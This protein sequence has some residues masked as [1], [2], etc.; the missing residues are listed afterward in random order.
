MFPVWVAK[1]NALYDLNNPLDYWPIYNPWVE[2]GVTNA[3]AVAALVPQL[4]DTALPHKG[5][6]EGVEGV[7]AYGHKVLFLTTCPDVWH[8]HAKMSWLATHGFSRSDLEVVPIGEA[9]TFKHKREFP[10]DFLLDDHVDNV[11]NRPGGVL[12]NRPHN[13]E[14]RF[15]GRRVDSVKEFAN[16]VWASSA[17]CDARALADAMSVGGSDF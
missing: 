17:T 10:T 11:A 5:A 16:H 9:F 13:R 8:Y 1:M 7:R 2:L 4:Y 3:Q 12:L 6:L 15:Y 14:A